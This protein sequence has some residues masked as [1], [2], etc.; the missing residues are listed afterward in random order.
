M[1]FELLYTSAPRGLLP[2]TSGFSTVKATRGIPLS[3][4]EALEALSAY[5]HDF[6][7]HDARAKQN[8]VCNSLLE[9]NVGGKRWFVLSRIADAGLD[10][11]HRTNFLAHHLAFTE[12]ECRGIDPLTVMTTPDVF[13]TSWDGRVEE[14]AA[15]VLPSGSLP[16]SPPILWPSKAGPGWL[17]AV[18]ARAAQETVY[19][20]C[21]YASQ[22]ALVRELLASVAPPDR[23]SLTHSTA[24]FLAAPNVQCKIRCVAPGSDDARRVDRSRTLVVDFTQPPSALPADAARPRSSAASASAG[25]SPSTFIV[26]PSGYA[27]RESFAATKPVDVAPSPPPPPVFPVEAPAPRT[28]SAVTATIGVCA[29]VLL[30]LGV[31]VPMTL[32]LQARRAAAEQAGVELSASLDA[33]RDQLRN[34]QQRLQAESDRAERLEA[35]MRSAGPTTDERHEA[36]VAALEQERRREAERYAQEIEKLN[37]ELAAARRAREALERAPPIPLSAPPSTTAATR[38][39]S[40]AEVAAP[41]PLPEPSIYVSTLAGIPPRNEKNKKN[42]PFKIGELKEPLA[43]DFDALAA[44]RKK[45]TDL[46]QFSAKKRSEAAQ[47]RR[48]DANPLTTPTDRDENRR[49]LAQCESQIADAERTRLELYRNVDIRH[50]RW[51]V[52]PVPNRKTRLSVDVFSEYDSEI[53]LRFL[54]ERDIGLDT[55]AVSAEP[56]VALAAI[57]V[58][59][60]N[61]AAGA[62]TGLSDVFFE[63][64]KNER[65]ADPR[66]AD[67]LREVEAAVSASTLTF[68][69]KDGAVVDIRFDGANTPRATVVRGPAPLPA[70]KP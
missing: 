32:R 59:P 55:E 34:S 11:T 42:E 66:I 52:R 50:V 28:G 45:L 30:A 43:V 44:L 38:P 64:L 16:R 24:F 54:S 62:M 31:A 36:A 6:P 23:W 13:A 47:L 5:R 67:E 68:S 57:S 17:E 14:L 53:R 60:L 26:E 4:R 46:R 22:P 40:T 51:I 70:S 58:K 27:L 18:V 12:A 61:N 25:A 19:L 65:F 8:P 2:G 3:L 63:W 29:G 48:A 15:P 35:A 49:N 1:P 20:V 7:P 10:H 9:M 37:A 21:E 56:G 33:A 41:A 39:P 69:F